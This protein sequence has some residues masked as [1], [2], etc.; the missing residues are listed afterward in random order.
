[1]SVETSSTVAEALDRALI[2]TNTACISGST[3]VVG[4]I[5]GSLRKTDEQ[6]S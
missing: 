4:E 6:G 3:Y 5:I 2:G 1:M